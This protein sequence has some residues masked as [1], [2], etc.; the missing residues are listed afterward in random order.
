MKVPLNY[1]IISY[2]VMPFVLLSYTV[3]AIPELI[4][5]LISKLKGDKNVKAKD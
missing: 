5:I 2:I 3:E 4:N 1:K